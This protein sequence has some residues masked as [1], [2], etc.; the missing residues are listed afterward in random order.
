MILVWDPFC[1]ITIICNLKIKL[2]WDYPNWDEDDMERFNIIDLFERSLRTKKRYEIK[3]EKQ[4]MVIEICLKILKFKARS[5]CKVFKMMLRTASF[6]GALKAL[7]TRYNFVGD[8]SILA[9]QKWWHL[10]DVCE[11]QIAT[12]IDYVD[13]FRIINSHVWDADLV[14]EIAKT[15]NKI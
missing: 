12:K 9:T 8:I 2:Y 14:T 11:S 15:V 13:V 6:T 4:L 7:S 1:L 3:I 10:R 5:P